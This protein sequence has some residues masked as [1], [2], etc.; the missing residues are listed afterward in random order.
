MFKQ[1]AMEPGKV[2]I[3]AFWLPNSCSEFFRVSWS[4]AH[5]SPIGE[6]HQWCFVGSQSAR[7]PGS[8]KNYDLRA[9]DSAIDF[10][11]ASP[12]SKSPP[13]ILSMFMNRHIAFEMKFFSPA[14]LHVTAV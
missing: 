9:R 4:P 3:T 7:L 11:L 1:E 10:K 14:M 13:T 6:I 8:I 2:L 5:T 12:F